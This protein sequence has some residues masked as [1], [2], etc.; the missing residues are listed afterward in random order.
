MSNMIK[1]TL[2][3][4]VLTA[5]AFTL[6]PS[7]ASA[8]VVGVSDQRGVAPASATETV[9]WRPYCHHHYRHWGYCGTCGYRVYGYAYPAYGYYG[10]AAPVAAA[11]AL[12]W[13]FWGWW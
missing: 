13:P 4:A 7:A 6:A 5:A 2:A 8:G 12:T 10:A 3:A 11:A 9:H 1:S